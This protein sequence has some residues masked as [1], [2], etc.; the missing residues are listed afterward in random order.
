MPAGPRRRACIRA[1]RALIVESKLTLR[2]ATP[3]TQAARRCKVTS[4]AT[5]P[6]GIKQFLKGSDGRNAQGACQRMEKYYTPELAAAVTQ[7]AKSDLEHFGYPVW[8]GNVEN[9][10]F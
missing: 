7:Y 5:L 3:T 1:Q 9:P 6:A 2:V 4:V 10:W 8:D